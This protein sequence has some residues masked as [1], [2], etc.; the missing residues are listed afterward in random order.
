[1]VSAA[2]HADFRRISIEVAGLLMFAD[3]ELP[4]LYASP[5]P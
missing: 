1:M 4:I 5:L 2:L 3:F